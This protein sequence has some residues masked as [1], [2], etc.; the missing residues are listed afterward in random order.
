LTGAL[1]AIG[2]T[3]GP[4]SGR[5]NP[6]NELVGEATTAAAEALFC[7]FDRTAMLERLTRRLRSEVERESRAENRLVLNGMLDNL[8][9]AAGTDGEDR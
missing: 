9:A 2:G 7:S 1:T 8:M 5:D 6:T 3:Q 4:S